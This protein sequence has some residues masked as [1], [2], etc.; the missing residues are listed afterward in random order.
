MVRR[1]NASLEE[2]K[3][4]LEGKLS[5]RERQQKKIEEIFECKREE[6]EKVLQEKDS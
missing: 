4:E 1:L 5:V 6:N 3:K 2:T